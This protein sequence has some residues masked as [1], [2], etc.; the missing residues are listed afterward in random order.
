MTRGTQLRKGERQ[1][2][3]LIELLVVIAIIAVL[4]ALLLP[5]VQ[6]AR[7]AARVSQC[8]NNLKQIGV[9]MHAFHDANKRF[10]LAGNT[11]AG[12]NPAVRPF[13]FS[14]PFYLY[15]FLEQDGMYKSVPKDNEGMIDVNTVPGGAAIL[16]KLDT[17]PVSTFYCPT[18]RA[19]QLY[20]GDAV[21][22]YAGNLGT[23]TTDGVIIIY[24]GVPSGL[25]AVGLQSIK[26]GTSNTLLVAERRINVATITS[27]TDFC[28]N[29]PAVRAASDCDVSRRA[30]PAGGS[31]LGPARDLEDSTN[32][33]YFGGGG[34]WQF[35]GPHAGGSMSLL[36][37]GSGRMIN[38][39]INATVYK[40]VC[41]R[42][43]RNAVSLE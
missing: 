20:H 12:E 9:A 36:C 17:T 22:D 1:G 10:P 18:R 28:D 15:P 35:G 5:A 27:G 8:K 34:I 31:W 42:N 13:H 29:E 7:E 21:S 38:Y 2:F 3:T 23:G 26:D 6:Q 16:A 11:Y 41:V 32:T 37:D 4:I 39:N 25:N 19:V 30:Q 24:T 43:D 40:N 14:W 33:N